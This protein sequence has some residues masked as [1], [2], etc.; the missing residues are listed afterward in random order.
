MPTV[1]A[2]RTEVEQVLVDV[3]SLLLERARLE[4]EREVEAAGDSATPEAASS[5]LRM[6]KLEDALRTIRSER[7]VAG[8]VSGR[9]IS[10][11]YEVPGQEDA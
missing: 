4:L 11:Y 3:S 10:K 5:L 8:Q 2:H 1:A 6:R 9:T 7:S